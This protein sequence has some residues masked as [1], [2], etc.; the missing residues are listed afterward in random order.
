MTLVDRRS[1]PS[2]ENQ[3]ATIMGPGSHKASI[4][5]KGVLSW[6]KRLYLDLR[7]CVGPRPT[8]VFGP[9]LFMRPN[10]FSD[11]KNRKIAT[12]NITMSKK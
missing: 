7:S 8:L 9:L 2:A 4:Q 3:V 10:N 5:L 11:L 6:L 12:S 1:L